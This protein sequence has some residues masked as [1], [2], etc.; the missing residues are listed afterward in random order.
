MSSV[1]QDFVFLADCGTSATLVI[2][3]APATSPAEKSVVV[4]Q[5]LP[6]TPHH[7]VSSSPRR[8]IT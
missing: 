6:G 4:S 5:L 1:G 3:L 7:S 2:D 8:E